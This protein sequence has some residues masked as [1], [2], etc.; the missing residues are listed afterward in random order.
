MAKDSVIIRNKEMMKGFLVN[1]EIPKEYRLD[2]DIIPFGYIY[3]IENI[4]NNNKYI[5]STYSIWTGS[6]P[7]VMSQLGK[8]A[9][10]Y[11]YEYNS[12][13]KMISSNKDVPIKYNR[14]IIA[15]MVQDGFENFIMYPIA[16]T[17]REVHIAAEQFFINKY[18]TIENGYNLVKAV[19]LPG[20]SLSHRNMTANEKQIRSENIICINNNEKKIIF[21]DSMKLFA[22]Y[23]NTG[24][25]MI[26]NCNRMGRPYK[27]WF[28]FYID[29]EK[30]LYVLNNNVL[31][32]KMLNVKRSE[33]SKDF[34][35]TLYGMITLYLKNLNNKEYFPDF[36]ILP[37]LEYKD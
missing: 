14:P 12:A 10:H 2:D 27:G 13:I 37:P 33:S 32:D 28:V 6:R 18:N 24:K 34:Y 7:S 30:R 21:S 35:K 8:R 3:C 16:E 1:S 11:L 4:K 5:G 20:Y 29:N 22:D 23:M 17:T 19:S 31:G 9:S 25:D 26:K 36:T 15:A